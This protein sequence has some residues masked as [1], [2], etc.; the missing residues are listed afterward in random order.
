MKI[1]V[2]TTSAT[3]YSLLS[4]GQLAQLRDA[5]AGNSRYELR[6]Q[7]VGAT[8]IYFEEGATAVVGESFKAFPLDFMPIHV[9]NLKDINIIAETAPVDASI[10]SAQ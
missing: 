1:I 2:P 3:L 5:K 4:A 8:A 6:I 7:N 9:V 10:F